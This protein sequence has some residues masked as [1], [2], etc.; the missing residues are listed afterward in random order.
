[1]PAAA[2]Q[3]GKAAMEVISGQQPTPAQRSLPHR[4]RAP[5]QVMTAVLM[6]VAQTAAVM[7][8]E[9][10]EKALLVRTW[11]VVAS[12]VATLEVAALAESLVARRVASMVEAVKKAARAEAL[13]AAAWVARDTGVAAAREQAV[14][15][16]GQGQLTE[17]RVARRSPGRCRACPPP[18]APRGRTSHTPT[19]VR[20][21][22]TARPP[23]APLRR[24]RTHRARAQLRACRLTTARHP[25]SCRRLR[26]TPRLCP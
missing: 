9:E 20:C 22:C 4:S 15:A 3:A 18:P 26:T 14:A 10:L 17:A 16:A 7:R 6:Q 5:E 23:R 2:A 21:A 8:V 13:P 12:A 11:A 1:M 24:E 19:P 25:T